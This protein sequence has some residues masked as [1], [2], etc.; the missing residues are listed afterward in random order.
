MIWGFYNL[1]RQF[2]VSFYAY[3]LVIQQKLLEFFGALPG[4]YM[5]GFYLIRIL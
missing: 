3:M 5:L 2:C 4:T 1:Y